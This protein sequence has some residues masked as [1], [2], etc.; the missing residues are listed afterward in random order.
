M[1][2]VYVFSA[3]LG[4]RSHV[5]SFNVCLTP[6]GVFYCHRVVCVLDVLCAAVVCITRCVWWEGGRGWLREW[7]GDVLYKFTKLVVS[8]VIKA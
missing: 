2:L 4:I 5:C 8:S 6:Y 7:D 1:C 3:F